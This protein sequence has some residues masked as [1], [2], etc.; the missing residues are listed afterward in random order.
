MQTNKQTQ[1][2]HGFY[3]CCVVGFAVAC[4][5]GVPRA[6]EGSGS[7]GPLLC[8]RLLL[9]SDRSTEVALDPS[10]YGYQGCSCKAPFRTES[11]V[12]GGVATNM[13]CVVNQVGVAC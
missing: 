8:Q 1:P 4:S 9:A 7:D 3:R 6:I 12:Q 13:R 11:T 10:T 2:A 5:S